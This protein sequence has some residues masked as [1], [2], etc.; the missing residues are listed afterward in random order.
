MSDFESTIL[1]ID[2]CYLEAEGEDK[3]HHTCVIE[4]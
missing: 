1:M 2:Y 3:K 4:E